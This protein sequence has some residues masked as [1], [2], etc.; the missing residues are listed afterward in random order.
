LESVQVSQE[1]QGR[2]NQRKKRYQQIESALQHYIY[3]HAELRAGSRWG[4]IVGLLSVL[5]LLA[6]TVL[7]T[8]GLQHVVNDFI[9]EDG[10]LVLAFSIAALWWGW[11][12]GLL[13]MFLGM[14]VLDLFFIVPYEPSNLMAWPNVLQLLPFALVGV[15]IGILSLQ[16]DKGWVK[17]RVYARE[18]AVARQELE[19][20][21]RLK[22]RFLSMTSHELKT[23]VTSILMQSQLLQRRLKRQSTTTGTASVLQA[24]EKIDERTRFLTRMIDELLDLSRM[25]SHKITLERQPYDMNILC[26]EVVEDQRLT[27]GRTIQ[28]HASVTPATIYGDGRR[29]VQVL[30]NLVSNAI[31]YSPLASP[32]EVSVHQDAQ[33]VIVQVR[34]YGQGIAQDQLDHIFEPFYRTP[35]AQS[36]A[37]GGLGLGL[38]IT[39]QIV[40]LHE[41]RIWCTSEKGCGSTFFLAMPIP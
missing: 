9:L 28:F 23:P 37:T 5:P 4:F 22:D 39:K 13:L 32:I 6:V 7:L 21:A 8:L 10:I 17:T 33:H 24:L 3:K 20:E 27:T 11:G 35:E 30:S 15:V 25:Q 1:R 12:P 34:D 29:L 19:D 38:A 36:S 16:R 31:K 14:L 18:L 40:D 26:Q 2:R 41:G